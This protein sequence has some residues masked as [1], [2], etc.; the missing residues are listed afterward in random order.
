MMMD[1]SRR[2]RLARSLRRSTTGLGWHVLVLLAV[3]WAVLPFLWLL[4]SALRP[5]AELYVSPPRWI[6]ET[7]S[8]GSFETALSVFAEPIANSA[9]YG[10]AA[11]LISLVVGTPAAY[12][13][14]RYRYRGK[15]FVIGAILVSQLLPLVLILLPLYVLFIRIGLYNSQLGLIVA[16]TALTL[17]FNIVVLRSY[18]A[19]LPLELEEQAMVDG[20]TRL[21]ALVRIVLPLAGPGLAA[22]GLLSVAL[23]WNDVLVTIFLTSDS[24]LQ[25]ASVTLYNLFN[26]RPGFVDRTY[27]FAA[28]VLITLPVVGLFAVLQRWMV[29]SIALAGLK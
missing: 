20:C 26:S 6:P 21:G 18:L 12:S 17:P 14:V 16:Y 29:R 28:G 27:L 25:T 22:T 19:T 23:V 8:L 5:A 13:L 24:K 15:A 2:A 1:P 9:F 4:T 11:A 3:T 10:S 7:V